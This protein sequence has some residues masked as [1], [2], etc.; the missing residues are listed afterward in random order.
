MHAI[1]YC[2]NVHPIKHWADA[3]E[4]LKNKTAKLARACC[5]NQSFPLGLWLPASALDDLNLAAESLR[6]V[7]ARNQLHLASFNGFP[8]GV[9]HGEAVK[10]KVY[11]PDWSSPER[12][13]YTQQLARLGTLLGARDFSISSLSG[14]LKRLDSP[15]KIQ[16]YYANW[17]KWAQWADEHFRK[18]GSIVRLALEPEPFNT[19]EDQHD[20]ALH[21][22][23]IRNRAALEK[24]SLEQLDRHLGICF[25]TCHFSVR[26]IHPLRAWHDLA[27]AGIPIF[28]LQV[29]VALRCDSNSSPE[30]I[31]RFFASQEPVYLHQTYHR[32]ALTGLV[33]QFSDLPLAQ[34]AKVGTGEWRCHFHVPIHWG[35]SP[36]T[37]G[38]E[39][40]EFLKEIKSTPTLPLLEIETYSFEALRVEEHQTKTDLITSLTQEWQW[41]KQRLTP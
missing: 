39:L 12:L 28:K 21:W 41:L 32:E 10:E 7:M 1:T 20:V 33:T 14:G 8:M 27:E 35:D 13:H 15:E 6:A 24:V 4:H 2:S 26:F 30:E 29:S 17:L 34:G 3:V 5:P 16:A 18:T 22:K 40:V 38:F 19:M 31:Q 25:D 36:S 23:E 37:T 9:F 11:L